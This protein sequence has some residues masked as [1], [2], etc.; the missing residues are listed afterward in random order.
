MAQITAINQLD[1][2][3][4]NFMSRYGVAAK[5]LVAG[6]PV[7]DHDT[8]IVTSTDVEYTV[9]A[10]FFDMTRQMNGVRDIAN[11]LVQ[12]GDKQV[13]IQPTEK[14]NVASAAMPIPQANKD[15]VQVGNKIYKIVTV[16]Q[17]NTT[18]DNCVFYECYCRE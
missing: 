12:E 17:L 18:M 1:R 9:N 15:K 16:K 2:V 7:Y 6:N 10:M 3:V 11:S 4:T 8:Q 5:V 13:F 14:A